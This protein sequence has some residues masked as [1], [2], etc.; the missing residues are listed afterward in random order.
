MVGILGFGNFGFLPF[1]ALEFSGLSAL[2]FKAPYPQPGQEL[3][4][5]V[6]QPYGWVPFAFRRALSAT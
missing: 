2:F 1:W 6:R 3:L 4:N 5:F